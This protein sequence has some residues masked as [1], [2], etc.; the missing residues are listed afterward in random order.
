MA[1][2]EDKIRELRDHARKWADRE[3]KLV[4]QYLVRAYRNAEATELV[5]HGLS[6]R[7]AT[8]Q[9]CIERTF[10][11]LPP[12][13]TEPTHRALMDA[14]SYIQTFIINIYGA[15]DNLARLW[16]METDLR[17]PN[18]KLLAP[19]SI[20]LTPNHIR[21]RQSLSNEF[22][23]YLAKTD[24]WFEYLENYR[25]ALAHRIPLYI[26]PR[27][28]DDRDTA[29]YRRLEQAIADVMGDIRRYEELRMQQ[30]KLGRFNPVIMHSYGERAKPVF[31]HFQ[32]ICDFST[33]VE[34]GEY[35]LR[36]LDTLPAQPRPA[37]GRN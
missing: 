9:H 34:I 10:E 17:K 36:E 13:E 14:T 27:Q 4:T 8:L 35:M 16:C 6:R 25:H 2:T 29:E 33:V 24:A 22:Q 32:M 12:N 21:V 23:N 3:R 37:A 26:P 19:M 18:G 20:G 15:I 31:V 5:Q 1:Y 11:S 7:L 28:L 30:N